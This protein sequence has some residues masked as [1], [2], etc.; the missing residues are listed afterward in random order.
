MGLKLIGQIF[1]L[2]SRLVGRAFKNAL[3]SDPA[4]A[5]GASKTATKKSLSLCTSSKMSLEEATQILNTT[6]AT[7]YEETYAKFQ[8][9]FTLNDPKKGGSFYLQSKAV[10]AIER[11]DI[12]QKC[13]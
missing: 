12:E 4:A 11:I 8:R 10:R 2:G 9:L 3:K 13:K 1:V 5:A 6:T 7:P